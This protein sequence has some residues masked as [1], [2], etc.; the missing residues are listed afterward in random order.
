MRRPALLAVDGGGSKFD[1]AFL[2]RD[3]TVLGAQ[4][5]AARDYERTGDHAFLAQIEDGIRAAS[6][7]AGLDPD[8][9]PVAEL[10]VFCLAGADLP[11]DDRRIGEGLQAHGWVNSQ[12]LRND[13][14]AVLRAGTDRNWGVGIVCGFGTNCSAVAPDG[15]V[16]RL[17]AIGP[18]SGDWGGGGDL[19]GSA[20]SY[21][22]R[23]GDG[24]GNRT[25]L[26]RG[27]P[28]HFGMRTARQVMEALYT[29]RLD[30]D[31]LA[32]LA[33]TV[34]R[35][36]AQGDAI[37]TALVG[38][39]ADEI[40]TM[41]TAAIRRLGMRNLDPDV[42]LGGGIFRN[43]WP[44]FFERIAAGVHAVA[45]EARI[46]RLTSPPVVGAAMLGLDLLGSG[47]AAHARARGSLTHRRFDPHTRA[48][49]ES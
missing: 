42:V 12:V 43:G 18:V 31:R 29:G 11:L 35:E 24:R 33:P 1:A 34:F 20:L 22:I 48:R 41:A 49:K 16:Y 15:R 45:P 3:G 8:R 40:A 14:F 7:D 19:G 10:G 46:V 2:R 26:Q 47:P 23:A 30:S 28:A 39:Q 36:A 27:V 21:A 5:V 25:S 44:P 37:A 9:R 13:T 17:P 4:R 6:E 32:E 38:K